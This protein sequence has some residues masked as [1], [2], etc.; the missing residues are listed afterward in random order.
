M[1][2]FQ[3]S[4]MIVCSFIVISE[5]YNNIAA[6]NVSESQNYNI[7]S[8]GL[9]SDDE[10]R[11]SLFEDIISEIFMFD[12]DF[13]VHYDSSSSYFIDKVLT[14]KNQ[15]DRIEDGEEQP[16]TRNNVYESSFPQ[17]M[18]LLNYDKLTEGIDLIANFTG[19]TTLHIV[20]LQN[21]SIFEDHNKDS[22]KTTGVVII[23]CQRHYDTCESAF[24]E[25][26]LDQHFL[27][28][29]RFLETVFMTIVLEYS[30]D[31]L[32]LY[33]VCYY[34][35]VRS[36]ALIL[37]YEVYLN[38]EMTVLDVNLV[39]EVKKLFDKKKWNFHEHA[40]D[41]VYLT[42]GRNFN[43]VNPKL[44]SSEGDKHYHVCDRMIGVEANILYTTM[45]SLNLKINLVNFENTRG[46][47]RESMITI[48][49]Q[50]K[51]DWA[52]GSIT[53]TYSRS[54]KVDFSD[55]FLDD[56]SKVVYGYEDNFF[57]EGK[58]KKTDSNYFTIILY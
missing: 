3:T 48:V 15:N 4:L 1:S 17:A 56:P 57:K 45:K 12:F 29:F 42:N 43:C 6:Q 28:N 31:L 30:N 33:E 19:F 26:S 41:V 20:S 10:I 9:L 55:A 24:G 2:S 13:I 44:I 27:K 39:S 14:N 11:N 49:N 53:S 37:Q 21:P 40:F 46:T 50:K 51:A 52:V 8:F 35:G 34:C 58:A 47:S 23:I 54:K 22:L 25:D 5:D 7:N 18:F 32:R 38:D 16:L 36:K